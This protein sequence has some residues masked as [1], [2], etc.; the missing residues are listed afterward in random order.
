MKRLA[1]LK[2]GNHEIHYAWVI[3][4]A[5]CM[6]FGASMGIL[7]NLS[8]LYTAD[9]LSDMGWTLTFSTVVG[10]ASTVARLFG[11]KI[12]PKVFRKLPIKPVLA[13]AVV[14]IMG[15]CMAKSLITNV[16]QYLF[17]HILT[18]FS[19]AFLLYI[20]VPI[21]LNNWF[22]KKK[23]TALGISML[24]SGLM[25]AVTSPFLG[26][27]IE[28]YGWRRTVFINGLIGLVLALP[29][30]LLFI[31]KTPEEMGLTPYGWE[32][33]KPMEVLTSPEQIFENGHPDY[34]TGVSV[35]DKKYFFLLSMVLAVLVNITGKLPAKFTH[36]AITSGLGAS[37]GS[38]ML[39]C[40]QFG[41]MSGKLVLGP[42]IDRFGP[43]KPYLVTTILVFLS[44][45]TLCT[46]PSAVSVLLICAFVAGF[47]QANNVMLYPAAVRT[48][49][50]GEEYAEYIGRISMAMTICSTPWG[51]FISALYDRSGTYNATFM[52][53][54]IVAGIA[55][56]LTYLMFSA[57]PA[58]KDTKKDRKA[59][60]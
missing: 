32:P 22:A 12:A 14:V 60:K 35:Q 25:A 43:K 20:P 39:S 4:F 19:G 40:S 24:S 58:K 17:I 56:V 28:A 38:I 46:I 31:V 41:N 51:L 42:V 29:P 48:Y 26:R 2:I 44:Y 50:K 11:S 27:L 13:I 6:F 55:V 16:P 18:G 59:D 30:I 54:A 7:T 53:Y 3:L 5:C 15:S 49:A 33:P 23:D 37:L 9:I 47:S 36:F 1:N 10:I 8:G 34:E 57:R 21:L 52:V 45:L